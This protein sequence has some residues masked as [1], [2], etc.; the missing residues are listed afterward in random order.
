MSVLVCIPTDRDIHSRTI[1]AVLAIC[2]NHTGGASFRS[3]RAHPTDR[4]RNICASGFLQSPH[5]HLLFLDSDVI[6]PRDCLLPMLEADREIVCGVYPIQIEDNLCLSVARKMGE[7]AYGFLNDCPDEP[8]EVDNGGLG[9]CLIAREVF[10][11]IQYP[12]FRFV[13]R[14]DG[15]QTGE[16][17]YFFEKCAD[18]G[19]RPLV[20][21]R[22]L[23]SHYRTADLLSLL[24]KYRGRIHHSDLAR[25]A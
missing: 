16:D 14:P 25:A 20:L 21:P 13:E 18:A 11:R 5:S 6:P 1:E 12:W 17:I 24:R 23:C 19:I 8:F 4:C 15:R 9:C 2:S 7:N 3:V 22:M 10:Q